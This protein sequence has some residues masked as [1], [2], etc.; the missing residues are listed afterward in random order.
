MPL[1]LNYAVVVELED[2]RI[3]RGRECATLEEALRAAESDVR[4][5]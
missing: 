5:T 4:A 3:R 2:G 1:E